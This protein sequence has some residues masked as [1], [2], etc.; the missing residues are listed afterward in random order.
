MYMRK[1]T[2]AITVI[3]VISLRGTYLYANSIEK[4]RHLF[5]QALKVTIT[6][7]GQRISGRISHPDNEYNFEQTTVSIYYRSVDSPVKFPDIKIEGKYNSV[8]AELITYYQSQKKEEMEGV[9]T[10]LLT[11]R[12]PYEPKPDEVLIL[13]VRMN[14]FRGFLE[15]KQTAFYGWK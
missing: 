12:E 4:E 8:T 1:I 15:Y 3:I 11:F 7:G 13:L 2:L 9:Y 14:D 6:T 10:F 5:K